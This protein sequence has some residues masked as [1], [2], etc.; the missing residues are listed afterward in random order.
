MK[1]LPL[2]FPSRAILCSSHAR[3][4]P[5][6]A[7]AAPAVC[8]NG[9]YYKQLVESRFPGRRER[10]G[11]SAGPGWQSRDNHVC[12]RDEFVKG[13][14][15]K[16]L[17]SPVTSASTGELGTLVRFGRGMDRWLPPSGQ[18]VPGG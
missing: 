18:D 13:L 2:A 7:G 17:H 12:G 14:L 8:V 5:A 6:V 3:L 1:K 4:D 11:E 10:G 16:S 9:H 15:G